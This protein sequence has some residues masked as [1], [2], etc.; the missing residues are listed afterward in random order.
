MDST[1]KAIV[2]ALEKSGW[3]TLSL[4]Q[5]GRGCPDLLISRH[6]MHRLV[7]VKAGRGELTPAQ[8]AFRKRGWHFDVV[9]TVDEALVVVEEFDDD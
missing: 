3:L 2:E 8:V 9:R 4:A 6:G 1:Q 7:E 5:I